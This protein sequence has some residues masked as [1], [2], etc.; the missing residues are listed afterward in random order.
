MNEYLSD[1]ICYKI[2]RFGT[3]QTVLELCNCFKAL[4]LFRNVYRNYLD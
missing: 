3:A 4:D 1:R 2:K